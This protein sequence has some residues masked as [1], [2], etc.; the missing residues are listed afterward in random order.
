MLAALFGK[1]T[2][3][4]VWQ[5]QHDWPGKFDEF[6]RKYACMW[7]QLLQEVDDDAALDVLHSRLKKDNTLNDLRVP[8][9]KSMCQVPGGWLAGQHRRTSMQ[10]QRHHHHR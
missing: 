8:V 10:Q 7:Q 1:Q 5:E 9:F 6:R 3:W 4:R 2:Y